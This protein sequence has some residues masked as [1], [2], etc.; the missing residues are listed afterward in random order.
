MNFYNNNF[1]FLEIELFKN[2]KNYILF[3]NISK[4]QNRIISGQKMNSSMNQSYSFKQNDIFTYYFMYNLFSN[5]V[6][7]LDQL[8]L[9]YENLFESNQI[10]IKSQ[11]IYLIVIQ[12]V[13]VFAII[14]SQYI[15]ILIGYEK[16]KKKIKNL[17]I[18]IQT[19]N[20]KLTQKKIQEYLHFCNTFNIYSLYII[21]DF[22]I[23]IKQKNEN[24]SNSSSLNRKLVKDITGKGSMSFKLNKTYRNS[25]ISQNYIENNLNSNL[26]LSAFGEQRKG[27]H[28]PNFKLSAMELTTGH[29]NDIATNAYHNVSSFKT[30]GFGSS[31][32]IN[33]FS[34][35]N[36][37]ISK[38]FTKNDNLTEINN[39]NNNHI[40]NDDHE[41]NILLNN[42]FTK[43]N[44]DN[45][46]IN[47]PNARKTSFLKKLTSLEPTEKFEFETKKTFLE[48]PSLDVKKD[49]DK[50]KGLLN[51]FSIQSKFR[52]S[53]SNISDSNYNKSNIITKND[54]SRLNLLSQDSVDNSKKNFLKLHTGEERSKI[55]LYTNKNSQ[56]FKRVFTSTKKKNFAE[57]TLGDTNTNLKQYDS[58]ISN[59]TKKFDKIDD[60]DGSPILALNKRQNNLNFGS[61]SNIIHKI[62]FS[63]TI[64]KMEFRKGTEKQISLSYANISTQ[65]NLEG[66]KNDDNK[67][68]NN[69]EK[70]K[71]QLLEVND[72]KEMKMADM[73]ILDDVTLTKKKNE[74]SNNEKPKEEEIERSVEQ[75]IYKNYLPKI[76]L[77]GFGIVFLILYSTNVVYN[78]NS[79]NNI[80]FINKF[81]K[82]LE[83]RIGLLEGLTLRY[84]TSI[85]LNN[86]KNDLS[87]YFK[88]IDQNQLD[89]ID[90]N[91]N[92]GLKILPLSYEIEK[93]I[94]D[95]KFC[96]FISPK[97]STLYNTIQEQE[98]LECK[99]I[100]NQMN[101][102]GFINA[103]NAV[104]N[105]L[106]VLYDD[107]KKLNNLSDYS[108][109]SKIMD[110]TY[111]NIKLILDYTFRKLDI[112]EKKAM[113]SDLEQL[114]TD[115]LNIEKIFS[116]ISLILC[117]I[118]CFTSILIVILPIKS[119]EIIISWLIHKL[120][121]DI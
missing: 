105:T 21:S 55:N 88:N 52:R 7:Y 16:A 119:V 72:L 44:L 83:K 63:S 53:A 104:L 25:I 90:M 94:A 30:G 49:K 60:D 75:I 112:L 121:R 57:R 17:K 6:P 87:E 48:I 81:S 118:F 96:E 4:I 29:I 70:D 61:N 82:L 98:F 85:L 39:H 73:N 99:I 71:S 8:Q 86:T 1:Y 2:F 117:I 45:S 101:S 95:K 34:F 18:K 80:S 41:L 36:S 92:E 32:N 28:T 66:V 35:Y 51:P 3:E 47:D 50:I 42:N 69:K 79:V 64:Q 19:N 62:E 38:N 84:Q 33:N 59:I 20:V 14:M 67:S 113:E 77:I 5:I 54:H 100:A 108:L 74:L 12:F 114:F 111:F 102:N 10:S 97:F 116:I 46:I 56:S 27:T 11:L 68:D 43:E 24:I 78:I 110:S 107:M 40:L 15:F 76:F 89:I 120:L 22:E 37:V 106:R 26:N 115:F 91:K 31:N 109:I 9:L 93:N 103:Y 23:N 65:K 13:V 58:I